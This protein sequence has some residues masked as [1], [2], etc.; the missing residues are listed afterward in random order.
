MAGF[1]AAGCQFFGGGLPVMTGLAGG[2][3][4]ATGASAAIAGTA[5]S[6]HTDA[7]GTRF[8]PQS[9][10]GQTRNMITHLT[11]GFRSVTFHCPRLGTV[12]TDWLARAHSCYSANVKNYLHKA[13]LAV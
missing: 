7:S 11:G 2:G 5:S 13:E 1:C 9:I 4:M 12:H 8:L 6:A 3:Q 10:A